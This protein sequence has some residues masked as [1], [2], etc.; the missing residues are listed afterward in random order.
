MAVL[1]KKKSE[2][3]R[4]I[5][6][7]KSPNYERSV[8]YRATRPKE[9]DSPLNLQQKWASEALQFEKMKKK[10]SNLQTKFVFWSVVEKIHELRGIIWVS[11]GDH[12]LHWVLGGGQ[13]PPKTSKNH[14][15]SKEIE[16]NMSES[17]I[18]VCFLADNRFSLL[19]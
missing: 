6:T 9:M 7:K 16:K 13:K 2:K 11:Y 1:V 18:K 5:A 17:I 15:K 8:C 19:L 12:G 4:L 3:V 14:Q 10:E